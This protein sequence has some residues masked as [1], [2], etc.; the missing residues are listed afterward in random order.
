[1]ALYNG[2]LW[3]WMWSLIIPQP[4]TDFWS[5]LVCLQT[6][7]AL[8]LAFVQ[9]LVQGPFILLRALFILVACYVIYHSSLPL[10]GSLGFESLPAERGVKEAVTSWDFRLWL[11]ILTA[12]PHKG[13]PFFG[14][15]LVVPVELAGLSWFWIEIFIILVSWLILGHALPASSCTLNSVI[16]LSRNTG[17]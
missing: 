1:M 6:P 16:S 17:V 7:D 4:L 13:V 14:L 5:S 12:Q 9:S 15:C 8:F 10:W 11:H 2:G 3:C